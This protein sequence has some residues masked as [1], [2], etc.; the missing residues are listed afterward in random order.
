MD[1][2]GFRV[3]M[4]MRGL[5]RTQLINGSHA[6]V[7]AVTQVRILRAFSGERVEQAPV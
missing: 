1:M 4:R 6:I 5:R 2:R 7:N 3:V